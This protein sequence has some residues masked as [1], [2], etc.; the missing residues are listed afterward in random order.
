MEARF[1]TIQHAPPPPPR[2]RGSSKDRGG[3]VRD[4]QEPFFKREWRQCRAT[5]WKSGSKYNIIL[6]SILGFAATFIVLLIFRPIFV[7]SKAGA[8]PAQI[9]YEYMT[10]PQLP[11]PPDTSDYTVSFGALFMWSGLAAGVTALLTYFTCRKS[12]SSASPMYAH[13]SVQ[14][15]K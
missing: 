11:P 4:S 12:N 3:G 7:M 15:T 14:P 6:S 1:G 9:E 10:D 2:S 5:V 13:Q 8:T